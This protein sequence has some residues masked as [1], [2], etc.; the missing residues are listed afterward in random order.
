MQRLSKSVSTIVVLI[1]FSLTLPHA[2]SESVLSYQLLDSPDG[3]ANYSLNISVSQ[4]LYDYYREK[5][6]RLNSN[7]D[8]ANLVT[9]YALKPIADSLWEVYTDEED[10]ANG[11]LMMVHQMSYE[12]TVPAKYP[13]ETIVEN[14]GDCDLFS[15]VAASVL[16][17]GAIDVVLL[18]YEEEAHMNIGVSLSH[19]PYDSREDTQYVTYNGVRY[20]IAECTGGEWRTGWRVGECPGSLKSAAVEVITLGNSD[21]SASEQVAASYQT[22]ASSAISIAIEPTYIIQGSAV[23]LSG[24]LSP[25]LQN[26]TVI[27]YSKINTSPWTVLDTATTDTGGHFAYTWNPE[28]SGM[29]YVRASWSGDSEHAAADSQVGTVTVL[30]AFFI[31][32]FGLIV[33]LAAVGVVVFLMTRQARQ[34]ILTPQPPETPS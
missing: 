2:A 29:Y 14:K 27:I 31:L 28:A 16:K 5:N 25:A 13:V 32:T 8:F 15:Y 10:F 22:L 24:R 6:H 21:Q 3:S 1:V 19:A 34:E 33:A 17:A 4:S 23:T 26:Q 30:S 18:Y 11:V 12:V 20:Y 9:P 7:G